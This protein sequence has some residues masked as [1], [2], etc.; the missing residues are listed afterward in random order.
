MA[1]AVSMEYGEYKD[2]LYNV[3]KEPSI[4]KMIK[5]SRLKW[6]GYIAR[7]EDNAPSPSQKAAGRKADLN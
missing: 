6:L 2:E 5:I 4:V 7:M 1:Q 3:H